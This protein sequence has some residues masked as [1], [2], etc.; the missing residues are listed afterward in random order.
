MQN[1]A[2]VYIF[3]LL[4]GAVLSGG[5]ILSCSCNASNIFKCYCVSSGVLRALHKLSHL[6]I[7]T[8]LCGKCSYSHVQMSRLKHSE[9]KLLAKGHKT[10]E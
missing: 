3:H 2:Y 4:F 5:H 6:V 1:E 7:L 9:V 8:V 10:S